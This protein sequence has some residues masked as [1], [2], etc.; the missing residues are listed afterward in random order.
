MDEFLIRQ[1]DVMHRAVADFR[2][3]SLHLN[4]LVQRIEAVSDFIQLDDWKERV[5]PVISTLEQI[6]AVAL[7]AKRNLTPEEDSDVAA[8]LCQ[9]EAQMQ[10]LQAA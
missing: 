1:I 3:G 7:D 5:F 4:E 6:N 2:A 10:S 9:L 8:A